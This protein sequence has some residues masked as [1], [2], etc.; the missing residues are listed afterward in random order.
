MLLFSVLISLPSLCLANVSSSDAHFCN[1]AQSIIQQLNNCKGPESCQSTCKS[2]SVNSD[3]E[4]IANGYAYAYT[5][6]PIFEFCNNF[7]NIH[8]RSIYS[9]IANSIKEDY[10]EKCKSNS[11]AHKT[12]RKKK[13]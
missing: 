9:G 5:G 12:K 4:Y 13:R 6:L 10:Q 3:I 8:S 7:P 1:H 2:I 11:S